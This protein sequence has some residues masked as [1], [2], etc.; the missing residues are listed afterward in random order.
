MPDSGSSAVAAFQLAINGER[1]R[2]QCSTKQ[3]SRQVPVPIDRRI[4]H[5]NVTLWGVVLPVFPAP[6]RQHQNPPLTLHSTTSCTSSTMPHHSILT[7]ARGR[8]EAPGWSTTSVQSLYNLPDGDL[9]ITGCTRCTNLS[10]GVQWRR[11]HIVQ[12]HA[13]SRRRRS[14]TFLLNR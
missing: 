14:T 2:A 9:S 12:V 6:C 13:T 7:S 4:H 10:V 11:E 1:S 5:D 3:T 8:R